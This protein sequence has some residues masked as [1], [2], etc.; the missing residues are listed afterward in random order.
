MGGGEEGGGGGG[1]GGR[2]GGE[3][4][5]LTLHDLTAH[6]LVKCRSCVVNG[7]VRIC[8]DSACPYPFTFNFYLH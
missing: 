7:R 4:C 6:T 2:W 5:I 8:G 1:G 3:L